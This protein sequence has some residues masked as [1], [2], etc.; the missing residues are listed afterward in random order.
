KELRQDAKKELGDRFDV[1]DFHDVVLRNG[2]VPL[3]V[4]QTQ[5]SE[6]VNSKRK[7]AKL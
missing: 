3:D 5:I 7:Q 1:R 6:W 4:L 2:A